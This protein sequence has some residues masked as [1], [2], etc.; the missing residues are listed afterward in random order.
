MAAASSY[1][2]LDPSLTAAARIDDA[3]LAGFTERHHFKLVADPALYSVA[4]LAAEVSREDIAGVVFALDGG[5]PGRGHLRLAARAL[6]T[7]RSLY[8]FWPRERAIERVDRER[9]HSFWRLW[10]AYQLYHRLGRLRARLDRR[11][12]RAGDGAPLGSPPTA[13]GTSGGGATEQPGGVEQEH[14][15]TAAMH[16]IG[17]ATP[18]SIALACAD[19]CRQLLKS[20]A[21]VPLPLAAV[22]TAERRIPRCAVY[23]RTDYWAP[24]I[25][26]GSYGHTCHV[27]KSLSRVS[28]DFVCLLANRFALLDE[29]GVRQVVLRPPSMEASELSII[30]ANRL[31][32][33][34][35]RPILQAIRPSFIYERLCLGNFIGAKLSQELAIPYIVEYNGSEISMKKSFAGAGY[36]HESFFLEAEMLAFRQATMISVVSVHVR[37]DLVSRGVSAAKIL[38][39]PNGVD[40]DMYAPAAAAEKQ[41][42][43]QELGIAETDRVVGFIGTYGGWHGIDVL[44]AA[45]PAICARAPSVKFLLI[46]DGHLKPLVAGAVKKHHLGDRVIDVGRVDQQTGARLLKPADIY[47]SPHS[48]HMIDS[49]FFGSPTKLFEYMALAGGIV[50]S[51]LEQIGEVLSPAFDAAR[52]PP[53]RP[54]A[55]SERAI[56]CRPGDVA[57]FV[58]AVVYLAERRELCEAL[59]RNARLAAETS[60]SWDRHVVKLWDHLLARKSD[61]AAREL[62]AENR[63]RES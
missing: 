48:S 24:L 9:L 23:L 45:M 14:G 37:D 20:A 56:L 22:P 16:A 35:L 46:G 49:P 44:A 59:G 40:L 1:L 47:V 5:V 42:L 52:L 30:A 63:Q 58:D 39:N 50:A 18:A 54:A 8:F 51:D 19:E 28:D 11:R 61:G 26:G 2:Y 17:S 33:G 53:G 29:L 13:I 6:H 43:R 27:A 62:P 32:D 34:A 31:Y 55:P 57:Q 25:S 15:G 38:V 60:Y 21:P 3:R 36:D 7:G 41:E 4:S 10:A 12:T